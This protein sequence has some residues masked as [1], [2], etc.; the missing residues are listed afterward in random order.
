M[1]KDKFPGFD[2]FSMYFYQECW[3][4]IKE[5]LMKVFVEFFERCTINK[6]VNATFIVLYPKKEGSSDLFDFCPISMVGSL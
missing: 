1:A 2:G 4:I 3:D 6:E 5:D